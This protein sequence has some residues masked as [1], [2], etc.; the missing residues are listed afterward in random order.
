MTI[1]F[2]SVEPFTALK[3]LGVTTHPTM[4][5]LKAWTLGSILRK[6]FSKSAK[7][8][9]EDWNMCMKRLMNRFSILQTETRR[10]PCTLWP[11]L[12]PAK[13]LRT[14]VSWGL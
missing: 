10:R 8:L 4:Q 12:P 3:F 14:L 13:P 6:I 7:S 1:P 9:Q 11:H 2:F 5:W